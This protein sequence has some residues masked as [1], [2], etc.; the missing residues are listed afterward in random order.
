M[1]IEF[2]PSKEFQKRLQ[3]LY[4]NGDVEGIIAFC[5]KYG[6][7]ITEMYNKLPDIPNQESKQQNE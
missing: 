6:E 3:E 2:L 1:E 7:R 5:E 4:D